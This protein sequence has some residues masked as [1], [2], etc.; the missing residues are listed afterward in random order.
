MAS[1]IFRRSV[2]KN[3]SGGNEE[4]DALMKHAVSQVEQQRFAFNDEFS[5]GGARTSSAGS[6][7]EACLL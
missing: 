3:V 7:A 5:L 4:V 2:N 6:F 1:F